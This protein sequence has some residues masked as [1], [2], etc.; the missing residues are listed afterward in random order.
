MTNQPPAPRILT[1][2]EYERVYRAAV[3]AAGPHTSSLGRY[4]LGEIVAATLAAAQVFEPAPEPD[5]DTCSALY[6]PH[7]PEEFGP[8]A[9][10]AWQ[11]CEGQPGHDGTTHDSGEMEWTD[12]MPGALPARTADQQA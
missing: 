5:P 8:D 4:T 1:D 6:L 11:Q 7:D 9:L 3:D 12:A 2:D 10:G